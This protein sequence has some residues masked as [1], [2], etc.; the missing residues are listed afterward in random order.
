MPCQAYDARESARPPSGPCRFALSPCSWSLARLEPRRCDIIF[1]RKPYDAPEK[2]ARAGN[3]GRMENKCMGSSR[4]C[5]RDDIASGRQTNRG[6]RDGVDRKVT[7]RRRS[8]NH[9]AGRGLRCASLLVLPACGVIIQLARSSRRHER[10]GTGHSLFTIGADVRQELE[11]R[12]ELG[13]TGSTRR[14]R[15]LRKLDS[16]GARVDRHFGA[17]RSCRSCSAGMTSF[18]GRALLCDAPDDASRMAS[19]AVE[20]PTSKVAKP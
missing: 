19:A 9:S 17:R 20:R 1:E 3:S 16:C 12:A 13:L 4:S 7:L 10:E 2:P 15:R 8:R 5:Q 11:R 14:S 6:T 18:Q